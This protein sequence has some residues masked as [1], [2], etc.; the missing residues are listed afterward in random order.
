MFVLYRGFVLL[1]RSFG[2][3]VT[4]IGMASKC[5]DYGLMV[6]IETWIEV[7]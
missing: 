7:D 2:L 3:V 6:L 5:L 1:E 4:T